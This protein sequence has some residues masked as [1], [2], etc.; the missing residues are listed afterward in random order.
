LDDERRRA[1]ERENARLAEDQEASARRMESETQDY[2][3]PERYAPAPREMS[4]RERISLREFREAEEAA[5][6]ERQRPIIEAERRA[7]REQAQREYADKERREKQT[8]YWR[9]WVLNDRDPQLY[10]SPDLATASMSNSKARAFNAEEG[11]KFIAETPE[12]ADYKAPEN[13]DSITGY[14]SRNGVHISDAATF[15][16]AFVRLRDLGILKKKP[17]PVQSSVEI[18]NLKLTT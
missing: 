5:E 9:D 4:Q 14:L 16:A 13:A 8:A 7:E 12:Y 1:T 6:R 11:Q 18:R 2:E 3:R 15:R 17:E 10:V